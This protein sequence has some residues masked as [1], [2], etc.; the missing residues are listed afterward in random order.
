M[1]ALW[2]LCFMAKL[3]VVD[4]YDYGSLSSMYNKN[5]SPNG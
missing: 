2:L 5:M 1:F 4:P 3:T